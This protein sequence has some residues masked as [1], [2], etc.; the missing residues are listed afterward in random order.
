M[1]VLKDSTYIITSITARP[2]RLAVIIYI[3]YT[4]SNLYQ[5]VTFGIKQNWPYKTGD[6]MTEVQFITNCQLQDK[7]NITFYYRWLLNR[8]DTMGRFDCIYIAYNYTIVPNYMSVSSDVNKYTFW[9]PFLIELWPYHHTWIEMS[10]GN[11]SW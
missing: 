4:Q 11:I 10:Y 5:E 3:L 6:I 9:V 8:G 2:N 7:K 1:S